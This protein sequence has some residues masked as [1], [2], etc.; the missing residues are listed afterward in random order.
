MDTIESTEVDVGTV[1]A[2]MRGVLKNIEDTGE[3]TVTTPA[4]KADVILDGD[5]VD[6]RFHD[7]LT[8][9]VRK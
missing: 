1:A 2:V 4:G 8:L 3:A 6:V 5:Q 9:H 7:G